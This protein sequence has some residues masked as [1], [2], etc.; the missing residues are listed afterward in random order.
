MGVGIWMRRAVAAGAMATGLAA[1][2]QTAVTL[3]NAPLLPQSF[4]EWKAGGPPIV[5]SSG[6]SLT[7]VSKE[8]LE[9]CAPERSQVADYVR[10]VAGN[11]RNIHVEAI[12]FGDRTGAY[13]AYTLVKRA[14]MH[15]AKDLGSSDAV[16]DGAVLFT[17]SASMVLVSGAGPD[18]IASLKPLAEVLP[19]VP[20]NKGVAPLLPTLAPAKGMVNGSLRYAIGPATYAAEGGVLPANELSFDK[21]GEA[22]TAQYAD[23]RGK[24]T[25]TV[26]LY[27]TPAIAGRITQMISDALPKLGPGFA[28]AK[29]RRDAEAVSLASGTF[30]A[31]DAQ[32]LVEIVHL[33]QQLAVDPDVDPVEPSVQTKIVQTYS[34]L[35]SIA[36]LAGV[37]MAAAVLLGLFLGGGRAL[38]RVARGKP[39]AVE[40]EFLSLHLAPQNKPAQFHGP[41]SADSA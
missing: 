27:P 24:E 8:A 39:A 14:G 5:S 37:L 26:L 21:A 17:V 36:V 6:M 34:L 16:G 9:E 30:S 29:V 1:G 12:Q 18:D 31:E 38:Y 23:K 7:T 13:S 33:R 32:K 2:A 22:V 35:T 25:L 28:T 15:E 4:G 19:K 10:N 41:D 40:V 3:P 11:V 20:G